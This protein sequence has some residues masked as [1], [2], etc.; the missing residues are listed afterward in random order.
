MNEISSCSDMPHVMLSGAPPQPARS[1]SRSGVVAAK[2]VTPG[3]RPGAAVCVMWLCPFSGVDPPERMFLDGIDVEF[4]RL[5]NLDEAQAWAGLGDVRCFV[6]DAELYPLMVGWDPINMIK[7]VLA[8]LEQFSGATAPRFIIALKMSMNEPES[9]EAF[10][11]EIRHMC[12]HN[13][14]LLIKQAAGYQQRPPTDRE[15]TTDQSEGRGGKTRSIDEEKKT[16]APEPAHEKWWNEIK[17][18]AARLAVRGVTDAIW[19]NGNTETAALVAA[20]MG[21]SV[22]VPARTL[23]LTKTHRRILVTLAEEPSKNLQAASLAKKLGMQTATLNKYAGKIIDIILPLDDPR[24]EVR[25]KLS[26]CKD[27]ARDHKTWLSSYHHR[28]PV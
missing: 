26:C 5:H 13:T 12:G 17:Q 11:W 9:Q 23:R 25:G 7:I 27:L 1:L 8:K 4:V 16:I 6:V 14:I 18:L 10:A 19:P 28:N 20:V 24:R 3:N 21:R 15:I 2:V 22:G